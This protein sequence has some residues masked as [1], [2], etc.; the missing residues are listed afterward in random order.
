M[1]ALITNDDGIDSPG[2]L[3]LAIAACDVGLDVIV[4]APAEEASGSSASITA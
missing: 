2:L 3:A 4:A 1:R